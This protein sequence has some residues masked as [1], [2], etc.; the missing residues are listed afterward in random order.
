MTDIKRIDKYKDDRFSKEV[1]YQH[2]A[3]LIDD[4][5]YE[6]KIISKDEAI[7]CGEDPD[8]YSDLIEEFRFFSPH[9][10]IFKDKDGYAIKEY[11]K[12]NIVSIPLDALQPSQFYVDKDKI[13]AIASFIKKPD[14]IIIQA[15]EYNDHYIALDGH[16]RL[17]FAVMNGW[18][19]VRAVLVS[20]D[21]YVYDFV[22]EATNRGVYKPQDLILLEHEEYVIKWH[23]FCDE[24]FKN[25][26][27]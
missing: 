5:P 14:D 12:A 6:V 24:Y 15:I 16:T 8:K 4:R 20:A 26:Q 17:Y 9:I 21:D 3:F 7:V 1:L 2:G 25:R 18:S 13:Q 11:P 27:G 23:N 10:A 22:R 19:S